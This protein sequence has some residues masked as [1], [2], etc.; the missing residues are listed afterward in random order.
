MAD[1]EKIKSLFYKDERTAEENKLLAERYPFLIGRVTVWDDDNCY[2][3]VP[4]YEDP[5]YNFD[6]EST[7]LDL[8]P[9]GWRKSFGF[10]LC[11]EL[12]EKLIEEDRLNTFWFTDIKEKYGALDMFCSG[13]SKVVYDVLI[14]YE[15]MSATICIDCGN[16]ATKVSTGW[17][18][19]FCD[20]CG[21][22]RGG[23]FIPIE[24]WFND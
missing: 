7:D 9:D 6:W 19:P 4:L 23:K 13:A 10:E 1:L 17:I 16:P 24:E 12:R 11:E 18:C 20:K 3:E 5:A 15:K 8:I 22:S 2:S 14:K 21:K